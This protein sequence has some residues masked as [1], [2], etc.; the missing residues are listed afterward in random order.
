MYETDEDGFNWTVEKSSYKTKLSIAEN[1]FLELIAS[2]GRHF[3]LLG[4]DDLRPLVD[5]SAEMAEEL[6]KECDEKEKD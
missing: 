6:I 5:L 2:K 3:S 1:I 4:Y